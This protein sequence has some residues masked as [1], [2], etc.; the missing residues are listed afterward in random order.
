MSGVSAGIFVVRTVVSGPV[1]RP[2]ADLYG[3]WKVGIRYDARAVPA[4]LRHE[5][6]AD[7]VLGEVTLFTRWQGT[8][9]LLERA[10]VIR[11]EELT[12]DRLERVWVDR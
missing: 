8:N 5:L 3:E 12:H 7:P 11:L 9:F 6:V 4:I 2:A 1:I 10:A